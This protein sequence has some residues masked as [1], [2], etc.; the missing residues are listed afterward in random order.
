VENRQRRQ[1]IEG[2]TSPHQKS[3]PGSSSATDRHITRLL[4]CVYRVNLKDRK[5]FVVRLQS[6]SFFERNYLHLFFWGSPII[7]FTF[8]ANMVLKMLLDRWDL[9]HARLSLDLDTNSARHTHQLGYVIAEEK[10]AIHWKFIGTTER[11]CEESPH[12]PSS[13]PIENNVCYS[14]KLFLKTPR[15]WPPRRPELERKKKLHVSGHPGG[16]NSNTNAS[17]MFTD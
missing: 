14:I 12:P 2:F 16:P 15:F 1:W 3:V 9:Y 5:R 6:T 4:C 17:K 8:R 11:T 7:F 13:R 10:E